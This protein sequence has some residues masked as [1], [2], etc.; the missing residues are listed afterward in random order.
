[1]PIDD[2][3]PPI[4]TVLFDA[5][6]VMQ[7]TAP[8]WQ[9]ELAAMVG[10]RNDLDADDFAL[11]VQQAEAPTMDGKTEIA[12]AMVEVLR[13]YSVSLRVDDILDLWTRITADPSMIEA[14]Q[15]LRCAGLRC[16]LATNQQR[17]RAAWMKAN[18]GYQEVFDEEFYSC[19][20]GL[21][22]P[23]PAFFTTI[24]KHLAVEPSAVL[25]VDDTAANVDAARELGLNAYLFRRWGGRQVLEEILHQ[26]GIALGARKG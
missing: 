24:L 1:V 20:L 18:L 21:A 9:D 17:Q 26:Q 8:G 3:S 12:D 5:D 10:P 19:D 22:K 6:G 16:C 11:A 7:R 2:S 4:T 13:R 14:V 23:D 25:F 15:D